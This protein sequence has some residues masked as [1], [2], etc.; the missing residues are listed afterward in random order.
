MICKFMHMLSERCCRIPSLALLNL[1]GDMQGLRWV[2]AD[3]KLS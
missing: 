3:T 2:C 1:S